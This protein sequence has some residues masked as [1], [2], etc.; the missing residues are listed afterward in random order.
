MFLNS[1]VWTCALTS[2]PNLTYAEAL[3]SE[4]EARRILRRFPYE[5]KAPLVYIASLTQRSSIAE[6][7][8]DIFQYVATRFFREETV[9]VLDKTGAGSREQW[10]DC[11]V[12]AVLPPP[13]GANSP[14]AGDSNGAAADPAAVRYKVRRIPD[15]DSRKLP[16]PFVVVGS[17]VRRPRS[18]LPKEKLKLFMKQCVECNEHSVL[19]VKRSTYAKCVTDGGVTAFG[20]FWVG[21]APTFG[22]SKWL[23]SRQRKE[24]ARQSNGTEPPGK[25]SKSKA[26]AG[27][28]ANGKPPAA[29]S[30]E[31]QKPATKSKERKATAKATS[32]N[33]PAISNYF[34]KND[35]KM[36]ANSSKAP[37]DASKKPPKISKEEL[38]RQ[39]KLK[40]E[41]EAAAKRQQ[42]EERERQKA[43]LNQQ[44]VAAVKT[45]NRIAEDLE[46]PD[47]RPLP[48]PH[49][50]RTLLPQKLLGDAMFVVEFLFS[51]Q[52]VLECIDKFP[53]GFSLP[54]MERA[55]LCREVAGPLSDAI[56]VLLGTV[57]SL[58]MDEASEVA[59]R[60]ATDAYFDATP[61]V[62]R[63]AIDG[64]VR[65]ASRAI[66]WPQSYLGVESLA[67]LPMDANTVSE[68]LRLHLLMSGAREDEELA[69]WRFHQ[70]GGYQNIDDPGLALR[71]RQ[72]H[73]VRALADRTVYELETADQLQI[74]MCLVNQIVTY[75]TIRDTVSVWR[76][77]PHNM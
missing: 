66:G 49:P 3:D 35:G 7:V 18:I 19:T 44:L 17:Q 21:A 43:E 32:P 15:E 58:Q 2:R 62:E 73:I 76:H 64:A 53:R 50:V 8:D 22:T 37:S 41:A 55:L 72:P 40:E 16:E 38:A 39:R 52:S 77:W 23:Q 29:S 26:K 47:Q 11:E 24:L 33:Q 65:E 69:K 67:E 70:R 45:H 10:H 51:F 1:T 36:T 34:A 9:S 27:K 54:L 71:V 60:Y 14:A 68:L 57:F 30:K 31:N 59:V 5:L 12:L 25:A 28:T 13:A 48:R 42:V 20:D 75:S 61:A 46:L 56:Q 74:L 63:T 4:R 6:L